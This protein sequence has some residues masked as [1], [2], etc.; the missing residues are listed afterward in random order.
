MQANPDLARNWRW[1][2]GLGL[3]LLLGGLIGVAAPYFAAKAVV[4]A[5]GLLLLLGGTAYVASA[6]Q[7]RGV[8]AIAP[9]ALTGVLMVVCGGL[10]VFQTEAG[11]KTITLILAIF[12]LVQGVLKVVG[13]IAVRPDP[14]WTWLLIDGAITSL[15]GGM[16]LGGWPSESIHIVGLLVGISLLLS[17]VSVLSVAFLLKRLDAGG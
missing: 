7:M 3:V 17:A 6:L 9:M 5:I 15:L 13:A 16:V 1:V 8:R 12:F 14:V 4:K 10:F 2:L 11:V